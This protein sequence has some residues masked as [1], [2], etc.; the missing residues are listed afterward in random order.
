M[1]EGDRS[2]NET[3]EAGGM[4]VELTAEMEGAK[5]RQDETKITPQNPGTSMSVGNGDMFEKT[6]AEID[7]ELGKNVIAAAGALGS[8]TKAENIGPKLQFNQVWR[9]I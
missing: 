7:E 5:R 3:E 8:L 4:E 9:I 2:R 6:L 1:K